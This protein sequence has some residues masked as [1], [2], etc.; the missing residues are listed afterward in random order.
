[1]NNTV[2]I[3]KLQSRTVEWLRYPL[4]LLIVL[5]HSDD[6]VLVSMPQS[7]L[8][9][10]L[11]FITRTIVRVAV[12]L[13]F[14]FSGYYF[15]FLPGKERKTFS[16]ADYIE[17]LR[18]RVKTLLVP[19]ILWNFIVYL[20]FGYITIRSFYPS[21]LWDIWF[22][23]GEGYGGMPKAFQLWFIR[24]LMLLCLLSPLLFWLLKKLP[25]VTLVAALAFYLM[26][27]PSGWHAILSRFPSALLFFSLGGVIAI[28][29]GNLIAL[30][31]KIPAAIS[32]GI[33]TLLMCWHVYLCYTHSGLYFLAERL[34]SIAAIVPTLQVAAWLVSRKGASPIPFLWRSTFV[35]F[36]LHPILRY[37]ILTVHFE[38]QITNTPAH[39]WIYYADE[40]LFPTLAAA[41]IAALLAGCCPA[42]LNLLSGGRTQK[43]NK[44]QNNNNG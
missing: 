15:F 14:V 6:P 29:G 39:F 19:Y 8:S 4:M 27:W 24:D 30:A 9:A 35:L 7:G 12:P 13:F 10:I 33:P 41:L 11:Y 44:Q 2:T 42:L 3:D 16:R 38:G 18:K 37:W 20:C 34:F 5:I 23:F 21:N 17:K 32:F 25:W 1:M 43:S 31:K 36:A 22:G 28:R 40:L 26:P